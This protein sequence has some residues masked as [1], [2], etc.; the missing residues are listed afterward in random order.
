MKIAQSLGAKDSSLS[1]CHSFLSFFLWFELHGSFYQA[2]LSAERS[3]GFGNKGPKIKLVQIGP[4]FMLMFLFY[5]FYDSNS[6]AP[7]VKLLLALRVARHLRTKD[8][9]STSG[10][11]FFLSMIQAPWESH[12]LKLKLRSKLDFTT[13]FLFCR[14]KW[15]NH[16][17]HPQQVRLW[18]SLV[19]NHPWF[20]WQWKL[21]FYLLISPS[22]FVS[23]VLDAA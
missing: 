15:Q 13:F 6:M 1:F 3:L 14:S 23:Q 19:L 22:I 5:H 9:T 4:Q 20:I 10:P 21:S 18:R 7:F 17:S 8:S 11:F 2:T 12:E 16:S